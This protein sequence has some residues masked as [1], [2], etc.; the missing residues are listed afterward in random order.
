MTA[1]R[2][3]T[4]TVEPTGLLY[5]SLL[6][7]ARVSGTEFGL[8]MQ[9]RKNFLPRCL[10]AIERLRPFLK[11]TE[12]VSAW[13]GSQLHVGYSATRHIYAVDDGSI[14]VLRASA[15]G[16]F[17]WANPALPEDLHFLRA[18]GT[19][20]AGSTT[21]ETDAWLELTPVERE[22]LAA[23][24]PLLSAAVRIDAPLERS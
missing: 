18:D 20:W 13:P 21:Q 23:D 1:L 16:L 3:F 4:F 2:A 14:D 5:D 22:A 15:E 24:W 12:D 9:A 6:A 8:I 10:L 17:D 11:A 19:T 7:A